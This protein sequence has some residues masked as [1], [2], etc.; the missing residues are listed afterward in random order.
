[1]A[2]LSLERISAQ[3]PGAAEPVLSDISVSLGPQ[4][5]LVAPGQSGS[6]KT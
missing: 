4:Q 3:Y 5:L 1:M 2:L 6:A